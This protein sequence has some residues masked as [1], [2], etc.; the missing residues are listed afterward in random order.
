MGNSPGGQADRTESRQADGPRPLPTL[1]QTSLGASSRCAWRCMPVRR[2][3]ARGRQLQLVAGND[4]AVT[5][6]GSLDMRLLSH[7]M[8]TMH[9]SPLSQCRGA[10]WYSSARGRMGRGACGGQRRET[11]STQRRGDW[12]D[13]YAELG[14]SGVSGWCCGAR[15]QLLGLGA[16]RRRM[17]CFLSP[18]CACLRV[19]SP[20]AA[21]RENRV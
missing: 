13:P 11:V 3:A 21:V 5:W 7:Q 17:M 9:T 15:L 19:S 12:D 18:R 10:A 14:A 6:C 1:A 20:R 8:A 16:T 2:G 4:A